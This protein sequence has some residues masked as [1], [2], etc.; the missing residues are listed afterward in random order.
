MEGTLDEIE[1]IGNRGGQ[2]IGVPTGFVELD[3]LTNGF[4]AGQMV[5]VAAPP[6]HR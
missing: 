3:Q 4:H 6:G 5:I 1:S 2:M